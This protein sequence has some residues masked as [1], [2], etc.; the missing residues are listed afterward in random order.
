[1]DQDE[2]VTNI[3]DLPKN[4]GM[5]ENSK[6]V[7]PKS[8]GRMVEELIIDCVSIN[9]MPFTG[10][11]TFN[12]MRKFIPRNGLEFDPENIHSVRYSFEACPVVKLILKTKL[13]IELISHKENFEITRNSE[14]SRRL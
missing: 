11:L 3:N 7:L 9:G 13:D 1:M 8:D 5:G 12:E 4:H 14:S 10:S 6:F 2:Y